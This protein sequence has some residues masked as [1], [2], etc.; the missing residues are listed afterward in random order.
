MFHPSLTA[1]DP[2]VWSGRALQ[3]NFHRVGGCAVLHQCIRP[4]TGAFYAPGHHGYQRACDLISGQASTGRRGHQCS[5]APGRPILHLVFEAGQTIFLPGHLTHKVITLEDYLGVGSFFVMLPS[6][7]RTLSRWT[8]HTPLWALDIPT[9]KRLELVD[10]ITRRV[11]DK[12]RRLTYA[13][14]QERS[15][16]GVAYLYSSARDLQR[17]STVRVRTALLSRPLS[18]E[19]LELATNAHNCA[20]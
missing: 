9:S 3:E 1:S 6:Y 18:A 19:L 11:I 14:E 10:Q 13:S 20:R 15:R 5:H 12:I 16:W 4:L 2:D 17:T 8:H 7:L